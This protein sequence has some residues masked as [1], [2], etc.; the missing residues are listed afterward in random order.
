[1]LIKT[2]MKSGLAIL[3]VMIVLACSVG[4]YAT[5]RLSSILL[6]ITNQ[7]WDAADGAMEGSIGIERQMIEVYELLEASENS[8]RSESLQQFKEA[9]AMANEALSRMVASGLIGTKDL[10][11]FQSQWSDFKEIQEQTLDA[12]R[13]FVN[14][15]ITLTQLMAAKQKFL[16]AADEF[17]ETVGAMEEAGDS[18]VEGQKQNVDATVNLA[19]TLLLLVTVIGLVLLAVLTWGGMR[20]IIEPIEKASE[21]MRKIADV[22]GDLTL[23]LPAEGSDEIAT[24][25]HSFNRF[26]EKLFKTVTKLKQHVGV[27]ENSSK[28]MAES[29]RTALSVVD[30]QLSETD[31]VSTAM[32]EMSASVDEVARNATVAAQA[33]GQADKEASN[34]KDAVLRTKDLINRLA[35]ELDT[36]ATVINGLRSETES[37]GSVIDVIKG[38]A[39]QTNL[40][41]LNAAIE[42]ARA[43]EQ[44]RGFAVVADEVRTLATRTQQSTDEI[45]SMIG[46]LQQG[47]HKAVTAMNLSQDLSKSSVEQA[48]SAESILLDTSSKISEINNMNIQIS[49]AVE[50]Q[51]AVS[52]DISR[53]VL[54]IRDGTDHVVSTM[55]RNNECNQ[56][57]MRLAKEL[58]QLVDQFKLKS[59]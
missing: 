20:Y 26:I 34:S 58:E 12:N 33:V 9:E 44:G 53:N 8:R 38:I 11:E 6:F 1:M 10:Q 2:K 56:Q 25:A 19:K 29:S 39:E 32:T 28:E 3:F 37:I 54:S 52:A 15:E 13:R 36:T 30:N 43:G 57:L 35:S 21:A 31:Q 50:E 42:A 4:F 59:S 46:R 41:A 51:S 16:V 48:E 49:A 24:L 45:H 40:L 5:E 55:T 22:D 17:L 23:R 27:I 7:A 18:Q 14:K 47:A